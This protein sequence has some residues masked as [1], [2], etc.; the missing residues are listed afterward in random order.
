MAMGTFNFHGGATSHKPIALCRTDNIHTLEEVTT[1]NPPTRNNDHHAFA[2][3]STHL[4]LKSDSDKKDGSIK[5]I[6][7]GEGAGNIFIMEENSGKIFVLKKLDREEKS[8]YTLRAQAINR[9]TGVPIETES[10]FV[11]KIQDIN[12]NKPKF[13]HGPYVAEVPEMSPIGTYVIQVTAV[14]YDDPA[15]GNNAR[16]VYSILQGQPQFSIEI[17]SGIIRVASQIDR[18][19]KDRYNVIVQVQ[20]MIGNAGALSA[21]ATVTI[22]VSDINDNAPKFQQKSYDMSIIESASIGEIVGVVLADDI[23]VGKNAEIT[24]SIEERGGHFS[25]FNII[26]DNITQEGIVTLNKLVDFERG[27]RRYH[28][29]VRAENKYKSELNDTATIRVYVV[30]VDEPPVFLRKEYYMEI[31]ENAT[32]GSYVGTVTAKDPDI[33]NNII[34][35]GI[36]PNEYSRSFEIYSNNGSI[37]ISKPLDRETEP[38][39]NFTITATEAQNLALVSVVEVYIRVIDVNDHPP[40]LQN[41]YDIYVCEKTKAGEHVQTISAFDKDPVI[42]HQFYYMIPP[43]EISDA[44]FTLMDNTDNTA[45]ILTLRDGYSLQENPIYY[46]TVIISD[47][48]IPSLSSTTTLT[49]QVCDCGTNNDKESCRK[50]FFWIFLNSGAFIAISVFS[51]VLLALAVI[52]HIKCKKS[53]THFNKKGEDLKENIVKYDDEGGGEEDTEAFDITGL[54]HQTV[55][56]EHKRK[57][58]IRTDIQSM[59]RLSLGLGPD[60]TIFREYLSEKLEEADTDPYS[61]PP[62]SLHTYAYEGTGSTAGSLSSLE[63][64]ALDSNQCLKFDQG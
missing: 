54:R 17:K 5:Y 15:T 59:Y 49:I 55:M 25:M 23:D 37:I 42:D 21:T 60:V 4:R 33:T 36:L 41:E 22:H 47:N 63:S 57:R 50:N 16:L 12:D 46:L 19:T 14:D 52:V 45:T 2:Q 10:E 48:G 1:H 34:R 64:S 39:H 40:E 3:V 62:D 20:D 26:T 53:P 6:L 51:I 56:R 44:N 29:Q 31:L 18:E 28:I 32:V 38:W 35:Y 7:S 43:E 30:D 27:I 11:I 8:F 58:T 24:Y 13:I 61:F 9:L